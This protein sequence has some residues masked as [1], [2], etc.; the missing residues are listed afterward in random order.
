MAESTT[1]ALPPQAYATKKEQLEALLNKIHEMRLNKL[2]TY[3]YISSK[4]GELETN[5]NTLDKKTDEIIKKLEEGKMESNTAYVLLKAIETKKKVM[6]GIKQALK[7]QKSILIFL[8]REEGRIQLE[9][10]KLSTG[11]EE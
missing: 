1:K 2:L 7:E 3:E 4:C 5:G 9:I 10:A 8:V 11:G 6:D